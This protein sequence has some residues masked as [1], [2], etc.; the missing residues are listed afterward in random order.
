MEHVP[1]LHL[2][3]II[4][5]LA[6][7]Y[8]MTFDRSEIADAVDEARAA[9]EPVAKHPDF[10]AVLIEKHAREHLLAV[11]RHDGRMV[12]SVPEVLFVCEH[13]T[14]RSQMAAAIAQHLAGD[15]LHVRSAGRRPGTRLNPEV[16]TVLSEIGIDLTHPYPAGR[17][18]DVVHAA[19]VVVDMGAELDDLGGRRVVAWQITDPDHQPLETVRAIRDEVFERVSALLDELGVRRA[20]TV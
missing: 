7:R 16:V 2:N 18:G 1:P 20:A 19:D 9:I 12:K 4:D 15:Q 14:G 6:E 5:D 13:N 3:R 17:A 11:A 10:L 8:G